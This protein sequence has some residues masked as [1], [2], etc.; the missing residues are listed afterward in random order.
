MLPAVEARSFPI[1]PF[2]LALRANSVEL[3]LVPV[4]AADEE[5]LE[6]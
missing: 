1:H 4:A 3:E 6:L 5:L 2:L